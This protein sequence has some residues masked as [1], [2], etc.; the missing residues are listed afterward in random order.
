MLI[1]LLIGVA[2]GLAV[3]HVEGTIK[4]FMETVTLKSITLETNEMDMLALLVLLIGASMI[5]G[6]L[7]ISTSAFLLALGALLGL[8]GKR[9]V[10]A[11][12]SGTKS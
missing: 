5:C 3:P 4:G 6:L 8:F 9:L 7:G 2:C 1:T 11:I 12:T 10:A